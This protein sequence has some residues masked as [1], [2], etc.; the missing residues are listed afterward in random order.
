MKN[1]M[2]TYTEL[3]SCK[4][5]EERGYDQTYCPPSENRRCWGKIKHSLATKTET[6]MGRDHNVAL[7]NCLCTAVYSACGMVS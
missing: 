4:E 7:Y 1:F 6:E 2:F 5:E 3:H